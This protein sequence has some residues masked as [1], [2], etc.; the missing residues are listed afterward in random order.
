MIVRASSKNKSSSLMNQASAIL[1][2]SYMPSFRVLI[3]SGND[4]CVYSIRFVDDYGQYDLDSLLHA[5]LLLNISSS[6]SFAQQ[7]NT[8]LC[9]YIACVNKMSILTKRAITNW[10]VA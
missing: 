6:E 1:L 7:E 4:K 5:L 9:T 3:I 8:Q 10:S 2:Q